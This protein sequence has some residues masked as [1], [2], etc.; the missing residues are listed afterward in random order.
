VLI[1]TSRPRCSPRPKADAL[2]GSRETLKAQG[3][4]VILI[5]H[6]LREI[7]AVTEPGL[8]DAARRHGGDARDGKNLAADWPD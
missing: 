7:M 8:G 4:T 2:F 6:K 1:S 5:T 3:K